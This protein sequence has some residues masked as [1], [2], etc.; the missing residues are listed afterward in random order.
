MVVFGAVLLSRG[1]YICESSYYFSSCQADCS[2]SNTMGVTK[3]EWGPRLELEA[4]KFWFYS[5]AFSILVSL[6]T[7][8]QAFFV[9]KSTSAATEKTS[10]EINKEASSS[11]AN[12]TVQKEVSYVALSKQLVV[13]SCDLLIAG[14]SIDW[15]LANDV[16]VG[17][18]YIISSTLAGRD[19]WNRVQAQYDIKVKDTNMP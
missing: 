5:I 18:A 8:I 3:F 13:D 19:I 16:T 1:A 10:P 17:T 15:I 14:S 11:E 2:Q 9:P 7:L 6:Y 4:N 12:P